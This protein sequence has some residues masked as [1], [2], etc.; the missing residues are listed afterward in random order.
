MGF[1]TPG[2]AGGGGVW[3]VPA[4]IKYLLANGTGAGLNLTLDNYSLTGDVVLTVASIPGL[5]IL[6]DTTIA[7]FTAPILT[8]ANA[9][10]SVVSCP[11]LVA[12][13]FPALANITSFSSLDFSGNALTSALFPSLQTIG[14]GSAL[15][16]SGNALT[17]L[18][19]SEL[20]TLGGTISVANSP[21]L[22]EI[23]VSAPIATVDGFNFDLSACALSQGTVNSILAAFNAG[24]GATTSGTINLSGGTSSAPQDGASNTDLV[25]LLAAGI[26]VSVN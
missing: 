25:A 9:T 1:L 7:S 22:T 4:A 2:V 5:H 18:D 17:S 20:V 6:N 12:V 16:L 13:E 11:V 15:D 21:G 8:V 10:I 23:T 3:S 24:I 26:T 14:G 19:L